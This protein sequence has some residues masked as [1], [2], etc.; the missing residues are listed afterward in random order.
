MPLQ[1]NTLHDAHRLLPN[2]VQRDFIN[3]TNCFVDALPIAVVA[4][5]FF[6]SHS[7]PARIAVRIKSP[8][9]AAPHDAQRRRPRRDGNMQGAG[10]ISNVK[11]TE[12]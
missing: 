9:M 6:K 7:M 10:I 5:H 11:S 12:P 1:D 2:L 4:V 3:A 8:K